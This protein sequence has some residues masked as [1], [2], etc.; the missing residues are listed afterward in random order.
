VTAPV[1]ETQRSLL[2]RSALLGT[3]LKWPAIGALAAALLATTAR[4]L[5]PLAVRSGIDDGIGANDKGAITTAAIVFAGIATGA[6]GLEI[7]LY[8]ENPYMETLRETIKLILPIE[9]PF[10][11]FTDF[12][13]DLL[14]EEMEKVMD[15]EPCG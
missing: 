4:L 11:M 3:E 13:L 6:T 9:K 1:I 5:G 2:R 15:K 7:T 8:S 14:G 10:S 12:L